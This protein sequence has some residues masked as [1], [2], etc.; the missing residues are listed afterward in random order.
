VRDALSP[1]AR[2]KYDRRAPSLLRREI[3]GRVRYDNI[4]GWLFAHIFKRG[5]QREVAASMAVVVLQVYF[6]RLIIG[7]V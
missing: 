3:A 1:I 2:R 6:I 4:A 7:L 5:F